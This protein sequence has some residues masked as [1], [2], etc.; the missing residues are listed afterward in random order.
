[1]INCTDGWNGSLNYISMYCYTESWSYSNYVTHCSGYCASNETPS[2]SCENYHGDLM[3]YS[4]A[5][6]GSSHYIYNYWCT[7]SSG[8]QYSCGQGNCN[9][10]TFCGD[11]ICDGDGLVWQEN[12]GVDCPTE[13]A[14]QDWADND[15]DG[16]TNID[17]SDCPTQT[18][19][20]NCCDST[21]N[22]G[23]GN[24]D[25]CDTDCHPGEC[26]QCCLSS[27]A[28]WC[29]GGF[30]NDCDGK[31]DYWDGSPSED[32]ECVFSPTC[33]DGFCDYREVCASDCTPEQRCYDWTDNDGDGLMDTND[34]DC[35]AY[36]GCNGNKICDPGET[37]YGCPVD[38]CES[39]C[40]SKNDDTCH[41][42]CNEYNGCQMDSYMCNN[43]NMGLNCY[44]DTSYVV[45][46]SGEVY[47]CDPNY[48]CSS[49]ICYPCPNVCD[50]HCLQTACPSDPDCT[51]QCTV[52]PV[53]PPT[54]PTDDEEGL[55]EGK[56]CSDGNICTEDECDPETGECSNPP[57]VPCC[58]NYE[59]ETGETTQTCPGDCPPEGQLTL[60]IIF[61]IENASYYRGNV[62]QV[63]AQLNYG[64][65]I[66]SDADVS[67]TAP[68]GRTFDLTFDANL[69]YSHDYVVQQSDP[70]GRWNLTCEA[71]KTVDGEDMRDIDYVVVGIQK[72]L[73]ITVIDPDATYAQGEET[74]IKVNVTYDD[75]TP[76]EGVNITVSTPE[77]NLTLESEGD[78]V[79]S[80]SVTID[81]LGSFNMSFYAETTGLTTQ[82]F[83][84]VVVVKPFSIFD[85]LWVLP[86]GLVSSLVLFFGYRKWSV[87]K[88]K[89]GIQRQV[90]SKQSR[91]VQI[92]SEKKQLQNDFL[93]T[94]LTE[95]EFKKRMD[96]LD[97]EYQRVDME[98]KE[99]Q[100]PAE[101]PKEP[102]EEIQ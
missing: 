50:G 53:L 28:G 84:S 7:D 81:T 78:G 40:T 99:I 3:W 80:A 67:C 52:A 38:C 74:V 26:S 102:P 82:L 75:G 49:G 89:K 101:T 41:Q 1:M 14:C 10:S 98:V 21:D 33:G 19:E 97:R 45:C 88:V 27:E 70:S 64:S 94:K 9:C 2:L 22:D 23:D 76:V 92:D 87:L 30:D 17:D 100:K 90:Q 35:F 47:S 25:G 68:S 13:T 39:D 11:G 55:C 46:C 65:Q 66:I 62:T 83:D 36:G 86:V 20:Y 32:D 31:W 5:D 42:L 91:K 24:M 96:A 57:K 29:L 93:Q 34:S 73:V 43:E 95:A 48:Y 72:R 69:V 60:N 61:P 37:I 63:R 59:C 18:V 54:T 16:M 51:G 85:I 8:T 4:Y 58:G 12:C 15:W 56:T 6:D 71:E 44:S 79:Y 77:G